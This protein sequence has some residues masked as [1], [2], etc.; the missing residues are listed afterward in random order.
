MIHPW[1]T[2]YWSRT[3]NC[4]GTVPE[5]WN[6]LRSHFFIFSNCFLEQGGTPGHVQN[7]WFLMKNLLYKIWLEVST[8]LKNLSQLGWLFPIHG[9]IKNVP[10]HQPEMDE[11]WGY[12][13]EEIHPVKVTHSST[14]HWPQ[15]LVWPAQDICFLYK[16]WTCH[17][18]DFE[19]QT[20][21][22]ESFF[23]SVC[24]KFYVYF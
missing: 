1:W 3:W 15:F 10:N 13:I 11:N 20:Q 12:P 19:K 2:I 4:C 17:I 7:G 18:F 23:L 6:C 16:I 24:F 21:I 8:P 14:S 22:S 5:N 9:R